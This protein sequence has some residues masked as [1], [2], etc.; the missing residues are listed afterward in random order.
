MKNHNPVH[1]TPV[2]LLILLL[3]GCGLSSGSKKKTAEDSL[4]FYPPTPEKIEKAEFRKLYREISALMDTNLLNGNFNGGILIAKSG[5]I[6]YEKYKGFKNPG[7]NDSLNAN[8]PFHIAS[9]SKTFT[10]IAILKLVDQGKLL[11]EDSLQKFFPAFP[12]S[13]ITVKMLLNH[14][15]GLPNYI[16]FISNS[17]WDKKRMVY[18]QNVLDFLIT[19]KPN[20]DFKAGTRFAYSNTNFVLLALIIE[21]ITGQ[22]FPEFM[23][24]H[25]FTPLQMTNSFV[26]TWNDSAKVISSYL[27]SGTTYQNDNLE[28]TYGD[29][30]IYSTPRD[31]L[32]WDQALYSD[33]FIRK[34]LLDSAFTPYSFERPSVHNYGLG[35]RMML[36]PKGK[37]VIYHHGRWHG[38]NAAFARLT[39]E[40]AT[41]IILGN[42]LTWKIYHAASKSYNIFGSYF[43]DEKIETEETDSVVINDKKTSPKLKQINKSKRAKLK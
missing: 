28:G 19:N 8:T 1:L 24:Q 42:R 2:L 34:D 9:T 35:W 16:Y 5:N 22:T 29:K 37:K 31:L 26:F 20:A 36:L 33:N 30:N 10:G 15:S 27:S 12:Y 6:I 32:K 25:I 21:K 11:L 40:K 13:N 3:T 43:P 18:N 7:G 14:R 39:D 23:Q 17:K 38:F 4:L 41:I